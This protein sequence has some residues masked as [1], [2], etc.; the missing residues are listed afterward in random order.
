MRIPPTPGQACRR[1]FLLGAIA[2]Q[3]CSLLAPPAMAQEQVLLSAFNDR[4]G[5]NP[6]SGVI[7]D[8]HGNVYGTTPVGGNLTTCGGMG[9]GVVFEIVR[10][11]N[12]TWHDRTIYAFA[13]GPQDGAS[14]YSALT[15]D[16][17]GRLFGATYYGGS[18]SC[19]AGQFAGCG[20]IFELDQVSSGVWSEK[21]LYNFLGGNDGAYPSASLLLD[22]QGN[23]YSTT[24]F[25]GGLN[26]CVTGR[27]PTGCGA[28]FELSPN[29]DG[30]WLEN[31]LYRFQGGLDGVDPYSGLT[32]DLQGNLYGTT[33]VGGSTA[34]EQYLSGADC[35]TVYRLHHTAK[36]WTKST[37]YQFQGGTDGFEPTG[38]L[39]RDASGNLY[40]T[41]YAGGNGFLSGFGSGTVYRLSP[42]SDGSFT[43]TVIYTFGGLLDG[44]GPN[45]GV[46]LDSNGNLY[47]LASGDGTSTP[48]Y[49][50]G[51]LFMLSP[52]ASGP[53]SNTTIYSFQNWGLGL[54]PIG[55]VARDA[56][57]NFYATGTGGT[58]TK[59]CDPG[60]GTVFEVI[61]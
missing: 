56:N 2:F 8:R 10:G 7:L 44:G 31:V 14:P 34:C 11:A 60:C 15:M 23:I 43:E 16:S 37:L 36:G 1:L 25:G 9:C 40:G 6:A 28:V 22:A 4:T 47:G 26:P 38:N 42:N 52:N 18:G 49:G 3:I 48:G 35:G 5:N 19:T 33:L 45:S 58:E 20:I 41:T 12:G 13:G 27:A 24:T 30:I 50:G 51:T 32:R 54:A 53:W 39:T 29:T 46:I 57:G 59:Y 21:I 61:P 55:P 17:Q